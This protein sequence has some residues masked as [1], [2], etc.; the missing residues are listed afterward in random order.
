[1]VY[2]RSFSSNSVNF[3]QLKN[4]NNVFIADSR[5]ARFFVIIPIHICFLKLFEE[6][7][8]DSRFGQPYIE[9]KKRV[10]FLI[11]NLC[12]ISKPEKSN[13]DV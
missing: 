11:P 4:A 5:E 10:P 8:L 7:E 2:N 13:R 6:R 9:Y 3:G 1:M 12:N